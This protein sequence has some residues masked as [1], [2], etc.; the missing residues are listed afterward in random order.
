MDQ[1]MASE[2]ERLKKESYDEGVFHE[3]VLL[4]KPE[5]VLEA[6]K[7]GF[8]RG[9]EEAAKIA[10]KCDETDWEFMANRIRAIALEGK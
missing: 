7:Q 6:D 8:L 4:S 2:I 10:D 3:R 5:D 9:L 1:N